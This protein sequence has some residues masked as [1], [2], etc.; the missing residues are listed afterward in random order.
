VTTIVVLSRPT[1]WASA[2]CVCSPDRAADSTQWARGETPRSASAAVSC[3][4]SE[5]LARVSSQQRFV[6][7]DSSGGAAFS[8]VAMSQRVTAPA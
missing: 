8:T 2:V 4:V 5:W 7:R 6:P 3:V 1:V